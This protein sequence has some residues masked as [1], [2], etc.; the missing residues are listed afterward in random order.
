MGSCLTHLKK[1]MTAPPHNTGNWNSLNPQWPEAY[2]PTNTQRVKV[3]VSGANR[4]HLG[5][6]E[7]ES[8]IPG[9]TYDQAGRPV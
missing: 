7:T 3:H 4:A 8:G 5:R 6:V 9:L 1:E 2:V